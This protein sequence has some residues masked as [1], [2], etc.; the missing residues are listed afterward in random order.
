MVQGL[1]CSRP[2]RHGD[3]PSPTGPHAFSSPPRGSAW[4]LSHDPALGRLIYRVGRRSSRRDRNNP[5]RGGGNLSELA[6]PTCCDAAGLDS[7]RPV[8][9]VV[10]LLTEESQPPMLEEHPGILVVPPGIEFLEGEIPSVPEYRGVIEEDSHRRSR[11]PRRS[12]LDPRSGSG[13]WHRRSRPES[14]G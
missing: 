5:P 14:R 10:R 13:R 6:Q 12:D 4:R 7:H 3:A 8:G 2:V 1:A 11:W 9:V